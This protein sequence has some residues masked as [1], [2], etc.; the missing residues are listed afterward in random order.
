MP[1]PDIDPDLAGLLEGLDAPA[2]APGDIDGWLSE[3]ARQPRGL[4]D[5]RALIPLEDPGAFEPPGPE[6]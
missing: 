5:R 1:A 6:D 3:L 4:Y 2:A